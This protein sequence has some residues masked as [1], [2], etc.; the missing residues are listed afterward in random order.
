MVITISHPQDKT[1]NNIPFYQVLRARGRLHPDVRAHH[2][3]PSQGD[4]RPLGHGRERA[5][6][7]GRGGADR[8]RRG[9]RAPA[10]GL[11]GQGHLQGGRQLGER[12]AG[13]VPR[14]QR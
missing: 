12:R 7:V 5:L 3:Q 14:V 9:L 1:S 11:Q 10:G 2:V 8:V 4:Q 6:Q 13:R